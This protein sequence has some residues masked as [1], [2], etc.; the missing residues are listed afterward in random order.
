M[1]GANR[2]YTE[3][4]NEPRNAVVVLLDSL[5]R[6][7]LGCYGG[8]EFDTPHLDRFAARSLRAGGDGGELETALSRKQP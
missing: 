8:S 7:L 5:N 4:M 1:R 6:H 2:A 3:P